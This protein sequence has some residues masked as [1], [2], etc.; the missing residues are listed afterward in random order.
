MN[1]GKL[2]RRVSLQVRTTTKDNTGTR[3]ETWAEESA[4]WAELMATTGS[5]SSVDGALRERQATRWRIRY[6]AGVS[7]NTHRIVYNSKTYEITGITETGG[8][9]AFLILET[10]AL[11]AIA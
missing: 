9:E 2:D 1:A 4:I 6:R 10:Y 3:L 11:E 8:R 5:E 7:S